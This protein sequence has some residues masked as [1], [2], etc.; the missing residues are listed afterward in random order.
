MVFDFRGMKVRKTQK[1]GLKGDS[2]EYAVA[3]E[4]PLLPLCTM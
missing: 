3:K 1:K 2:S 4:L